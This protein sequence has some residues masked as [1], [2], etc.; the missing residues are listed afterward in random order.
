MYGLA[1]NFF[2]GKIQLLLQI[3]I[4]KCKYEGPYFVGKIEETKGKRKHNPFPSLTLA[5]RSKKG[6]AGALTSGQ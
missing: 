5:K 1:C 3:F 2:G 6:L 4:E